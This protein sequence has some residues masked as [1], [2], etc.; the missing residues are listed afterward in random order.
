L[1]VPKYHEAQRIGEKVILT[2]GSYQRHRCESQ[3]NK[4]DGGKCVNELLL[5]LGGLLI[6]KVLGFL[7]EDINAPY[8]AD[9]AEN[10]NEI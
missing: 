6:L 8:L 4:V 2:A 3:E 7:N 5:P 1:C 10:H 9:S